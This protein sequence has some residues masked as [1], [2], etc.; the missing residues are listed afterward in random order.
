MSLPRSNLLRALPGSQRTVN[1]VAYEVLPATDA[2]AAQAAYLLALST[3]ETAD[4]LPTAP[5]GS[6]PIFTDESGA[7]FTVHD[8]EDGPVTLPAAIRPSLRHD[9]A[10]AAA[11]GMINQQDAEDLRGAVTKLYNADRALYPA[12]VE[13]SAKRPN[14]VA[15]AT[16]GLLKS[17]MS[18]GFSALTTSLASDGNVLDNLKKLVPGGCMG[19]GS[20]GDLFS[21]A[22]LA[23]GAGMLTGQI[24]GMA[25]GALNDALFGG[26]DDESSMGA[27]LGAFAGQKAMGELESMAT[28]E[29]TELIEGAIDPASV[30]APTAE[31]AKSTSQK[32]REFFGG[33]SSTATMPAARL[34]DSTAHGG[35]ID[36]SAA[37]T[38]FNGR[39]AARALDHQTCPL[40]EPG[41]VPHVGGPIREG[42]PTIFIEN[43]L[44]AR[45][46]HMVICTPVG[47]QNPIAGGS[48][49]ILLG[50]QTAAVLPPPIP[51][52]LPSA[53][54]EA[55]KGAAGAAIGA[56]GGGGDAKSNEKAKE[57]TPQK[58]ND[59][60]P[61]QSLPVETGDDE[62]GGMSKNPEEDANPVD[63]D[64]Q[65]GNPDL[66]SNPTTPDGRQEMLREQ[67]LKN[68]ASGMN[69]L[70]AQVEAIRSMNDRGVPLERADLY[71]VF[72]GFEGSGPSVGNPYSPTSPFYTKL[73]DDGMTPSVRD[74]TSNQTFHIWSHMQIASEQGH[75][76][77]FIANTFHEHLS[78]GVSYILSGQSGGSSYQDYVA[79]VVARNIGQGLRDGSLTIRDLPDRLKT[80]LG[81]HNGAG[82]SFLNSGILTKLGSLNLPVARPKK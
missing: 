74:Y 34:G 78:P 22:N 81:T 18:E 11:G 15:L 60:G 5:R 53:A 3:A 82:A 41:P 68:K 63:A 48:G 43:M 55:G 8:S 52:E 28:E 24:A 25:F 57:E 62:E 80:D 23:A 17:A 67:V 31:D 50:P 4:E 36:T 30:P 69:D 20:V 13:T 7:F 19:G 37:Q 27:Q 64:H 58:A 66:K 1:I 2:A 40:V 33:V 14:L 44:A 65:C 9:P 47:L 26:I 76:M 61:N 71:S 21:A 49:N 16:A 46:G 72:T 6:R 70:D 79:G 54:A 38:F 32:I 51:V 75:G 56:G 77:A 12:A 73:G 42:N 59:E 35:K 39:L 10:G 45:I 29:L